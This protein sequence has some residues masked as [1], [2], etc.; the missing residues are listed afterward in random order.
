M[1][2]VGNKWGEEYGSHSYP[3][4][5]PELNY[6]ERNSVQPEKLFMSDHGTQVV[7]TDLN[8]LPAVFPN[9]SA[10][11]IAASVVVTVSA[12]IISGRTWAAFLASSSCALERMK[13]KHSQVKKKYR[14]P[15]WDYKFN[16]KY[17]RPDFLQGEW[18]W[19][20]IRPP[21]LVLRGKVEEEVTWNAI[22]QEGQ[23]SKILYVSLHW[24]SILVP[25]VR[26]LLSHDRNHVHL[27]VFLTAQ[28]PTSIWRLYI[29]ITHI[30]SVQY[31]TRAIHVVDL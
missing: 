21:P 27:P 9:G 5:Y 29:N 16:R 24:S 11:S 3:Q 23:P 13:Y 12:R 14:M 2:V 7:W 4:G 18:Y 10:W 22:C 28:L 26:W 25:P 1:W 20:E 15:E 17:K 8:T 6:K 31:N 30:L 19:Q